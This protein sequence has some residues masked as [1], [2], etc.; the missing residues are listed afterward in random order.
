MKRVSYLF[1]AVVGAIGI[2]FVLTIFQ[3]VSEKKPEPT[4][5]GEIPVPAEIPPPEM[6]KL[7]QVDK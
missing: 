5:A 2:V 3:V 6:P 4:P 7:P 1:W